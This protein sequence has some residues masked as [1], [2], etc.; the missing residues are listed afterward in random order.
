MSLLEIFSLL[1]GVGL[2]LYG[3]TLMSTGLRNAAGDKLRVILEKATGNRIMA[4]LVGV[5]V[6]LMIQSSSATDVMVIGFVNSGLMTLTQAI[7]VIMGANIGTTITAQ[8]T[9]FNLSA[10]APLILFTGAVMYLF[11]K[12]SLVRDIGSIIM[13]FGMLFFG[14]GTMKTAIIPLSQ[15]PQFVQILAGLQHPLAAIL[16]GVA[17]TALLQSSSSSIVIFQTFAA[18]GIL[19]YRTAVYLVI[20]AAVGSVTPNLLAS[21]TANRNGKRTA[22]L[23][24]VFNLIRA[25][26]LGTLIT[27]VPGILAMIQ[28]LSPGDIAR[29]IANTHTIFAICAVVLE[30]PIAGLI[31]KLSQRLIPIRPEETKKAED[32]QL[33]YINQLDDIPAAVALN[34]AKLEVGRMGHFAVDNLQ[35]AIDCFFDNDPDKVEAVLSAEDTVDFLDHSITEALIRLRA[36]TLNARDQ[37]RLSKLLLVVSDLERIS[38]HAVNITEYLVKLRERKGFISELGMND[39]RE[40]AM[41]TMESI[42]Y[43][44]DVFETEDYSRLQ[45]AELLEQTVDRMQDTCVANHVE[46]LMGGTCDPFGG[47]V[48]SDLVVDLERC[49]DHAC[50]IAFALSGKEEDDIL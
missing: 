28:R 20:G 12:K 25:A 30:F 7:G 35:A 40:M 15:T 24:L 31:V 23:N 42:R 34:S 8:L 44:L 43:S 13:G 1:G 5:L 21:L 11:I 17:F 10:Y 14:I 37:A 18:Q 46:R 33:I 38:D 9:A 48:Y 29:Q 3:M 16:F 4:V 50:N 45:N 2:F 26:V 39:L 32:Q 49:S 36:N 19:D 47:V 22:V 41:L 6:T 27:L